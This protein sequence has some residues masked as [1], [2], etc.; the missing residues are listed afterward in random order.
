MQIKGY[1]FEILESFQSFIHNMAENIGI[2]VAEAWATPA[3]TWQAFTYAEESTVVQDTYQL[4]LY[5]RNIQ[6][7][8]SYFNVLLHFSYNYL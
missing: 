8:I 6:I 5:E 1:N 3:T 4:D 2:D 7:G